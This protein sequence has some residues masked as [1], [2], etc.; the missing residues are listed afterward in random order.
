MATDHLAYLDKALESLAGAESEF[1]NQR[2]NNC[3][4]RCYYAMFQAAIAA[5]IAA[6]GQPVNVKEQWGHDYVQAQFSG[7]LVHRRKLYPSELGRLLSE[8]IETRVTADYH[9]NM[10]SHKTAER[11][12]HKA[13]VFV[14]AV[15]GGYYE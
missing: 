2:Y 15:K 11:S 9:P 8:V 6:G 14:V 10:I 13:K 4:N 12:L 3:A 1:A 7:L 5:L